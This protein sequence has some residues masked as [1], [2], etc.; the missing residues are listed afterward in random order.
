M[1]LPASSPWHYLMNSFDFLRM[2]LF[3]VVSGYVYARHRATAGS[4]RTFLSKKAL[5]LGAPLLFLTAVMIE[6]RRFAYRDPTTFFQA[7]FFH[8]QHLWF[9]QAL[10]LIF[11]AI[12]VSDSFARMNTTGLVLAGFGAVMV[13]RSFP[14]T[15]L[16]SLNGAF[17]LAPFFLF[18]VILRTEPALLRSASSLRASFSIV[19]VVLLVQQAGM[20]GEANPLDRYSLPAALCGCAAAYGLFVICPR[21]AMLETIGTYSYTIYLWHSISSAALRPFAE[22]L[23]LAGEAEFLLLLATGIALPIAIHKA[24]EQVPVLCT[25]AAGIR[26]PLSSTNPMLKSWLGFIDQSHHPSVRPLSAATHGS[27]AGD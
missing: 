3:T 8:Y 27:V 14:V 25:L 24:V 17:Y 2:P 11:L 15:S 12:A 20:H 19:A 5:R 13:S 26:R 21:V 16:F 7:L 22:Q 1:H 6:L 23:G 4:L 10:L 18:G 9:L